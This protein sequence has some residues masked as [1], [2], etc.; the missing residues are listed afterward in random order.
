MNKIRR[1]V[2]FGAVLTAVAVVITLGT[3]SRAI[4]QAVRAALV[5]NQDE[6]GRNPYS[7]NAECSG[8]GCSVTFSPVP[9]GQRLVVTFLNGAV[10]ADPGTALFLGGH[11]HEIRLLPTVHS[12]GLEVANSPVVV[13]YD[14]GE[15]PTV[16]CNGCNDSAL[17]ATLSGYF[18]ALP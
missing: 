10:A 9:A 3:E 13:F 1:F 6:P 17:L 7:Q 18:V 16:G 8:S 15:A 2:W 12:S 11:S 14:A 4:A 5:R